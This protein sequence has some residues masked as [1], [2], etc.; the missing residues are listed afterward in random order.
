M[1]EMNSIVEF[2][3]SIADQEAP[4]PIPEREYIA[5]V[6]KAEIA[7][8]TKGTR[9]AAVEFTIDP[10]EI[11]ADFPQEQIPDGGVKLV[12]RRAS[13]EDNPNARYRLKKFIMAL[14]APMPGKLLDVNEWIGLTA[15]VSIAHTEYEG[16][17]R[18]EIKKIEAA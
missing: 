2:T 7:E 14:G 16:E 10:N 11:P 8:S 13:L 15:K 18:A 12:Y 4:L 1:S 9:Y 3:D 5:T 6:S 17:K